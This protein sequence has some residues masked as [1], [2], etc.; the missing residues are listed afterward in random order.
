[1]N[2]ACEGWRELMRAI[3]GPVNKTRPQIIAAAVASGLVVAGGA[4]WIGSGSTTP[5]VIGGWAMP[6]ASGSAIGLASSPTEQRREGYI[7][8]GASWEGRD[9]LLHLGSE[10]PTCIGTDTATTTHVHLG[11]VKVNSDLASWTHVIWVRCL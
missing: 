6:N 3:P 7:V 5:D 11:I 8:A 9:N 4:W 10:V 1:M 2:H